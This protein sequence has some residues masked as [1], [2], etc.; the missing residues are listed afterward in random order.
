MLRLV[1]IF[2]LNKNLNFISY[3]IIFIELSK[4]SLIHIS[5]EL[6]A[7]QMRETH[8]FKDLIIIISVFLHY[9]NQIQFKLN[10]RVFTALSY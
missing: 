8:Y 4:S 7:K 3:E 9:I 5:Y 2:F 10:N 6:I 1:P